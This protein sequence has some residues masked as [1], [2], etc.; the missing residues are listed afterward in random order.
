MKSLTDEQLVEL[1]HQGKEDAFNELYSRYIG[2]VKYFCRN[3]YLIGAEEVDLVQEG[4]LGFIKAV[5]GFRG[6]ES[7]FKTYLTACVKSS[8]FTAV[9]KYSG[10]KSSPLNGSVK[11]ETLDGLGVFSPPPED[12]ILINE[13]GNELTAK[14]YS[15]LSKFEKLVLKYYLEGYGYLEIADKTGKDVKSVGNALSR[16]RNKIIKRLGD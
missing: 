1:Y 9:K 10:L 11:L 14:I 16:C 3:L 4:M 12:Q 5:N 7:Q 13:S 8:L 15:N 2:L 6:G